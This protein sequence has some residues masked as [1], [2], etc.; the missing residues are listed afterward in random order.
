[1]RRTHQVGLIPPDAQSP[2]PPAAAPPQG[3]DELDAAGLPLLMSTE[4]RSLR[5]GLRRFIGDV[6]RFRG[7]VCMAITVEQHALTVL[8]LLVATAP[9]EDVRRAFADCA[10]RTLQQ[11]ADLEQALR[12]L[13]AEPSAEPSTA[14]DRL[15][16]QLLARVS[17]G[18]RVPGH[19]VL[20]TGL[21]L[22]RFEAAVYAVLAAGARA[23][24][25][26]DVRNLLEVNRIRAAMSRDL[27]TGSAAARVDRRF[28][29]RVQTGA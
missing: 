10:G 8:G 7:R 1:M 14:T 24:G 28:R 3:T 25:R 22:H 21:R 2:A 4:L 11:I 20:V 9:E 6:G 27:L 12:L 26:E 5:E 13:R 29:P 17:H 19:E 18:V 16:E 15:T 23:L